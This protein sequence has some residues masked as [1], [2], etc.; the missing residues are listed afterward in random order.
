[1][2]SLDAFLNFL[3]DFSLSSY[4]FSDLQRPNI[5]NQLIKL[6]FNMTHLLK[7]HL[8]HQL[9]SFIGN[10]NHTET[11]FFVKP[12]FFNRLFLILL[13]QKL[14]HGFHGAIDYLDLHPSFKYLQGHFL[15]IFDDLSDPILYFL[16][17]FSDFR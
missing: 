11:L 12:D 2:L 15:R 16:P 8:F 5:D 4:Y 10:F 3:L 6:I 1:M 7:M 17:V 13:A 9:S 14:F